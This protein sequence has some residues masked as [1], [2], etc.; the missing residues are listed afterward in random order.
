MFMIAILIFRYSFIT[1]YSNNQFINY[2]TDVCDIFWSLLKRWHLS[3]QLPQN[4]SCIYGGNLARILSK[5]FWKEFRSEFIKTKIF[6]FFSS[7]SIM[8]IIYGR[9]SGK[10]RTHSLFLLV[11]KLLLQRNLKKFCRIKILQSM[12]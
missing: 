11:R 3:V 12:S 1:F 5:M 9:V 6:E 4:G 2:W 8:G 7:S 10:I